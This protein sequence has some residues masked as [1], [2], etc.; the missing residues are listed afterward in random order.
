MPIYISG[1]AS[2]PKLVRQFDVRDLVSV[3][4][5]EAQP[6]TPPEISS[7][8]HHRCRVDDIVESR[9]GHTV[10]QSE[11]IAELIEFLHSW[12]T[13]TGL[14]I[15]CMAGVSRSTAVGLIAHVLKTNDPRR[16]V[17]DLRRAAPYAWP[18]RRIVSL[19]DSILGLNGKLNHALKEMGPA[20]WQSDAEYVV[21]RLHE[22]DV[23]GSGPGRCATLIV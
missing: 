17:M 3:I 10:P 5:A 7:D 2:M 21:P 4:N 22:S 14:L 18:N 1:L 9:P 23:R 12:D 13:H 11:H 20:N 16:S 6:P 8:R 19:A 15:H